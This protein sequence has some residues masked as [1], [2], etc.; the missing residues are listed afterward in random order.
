MSGAVR[1]ST[2]QA[3]RQLGISTRQLD[4]LVRRGLATPVV[5]AQGSGYYRE[6]PAA[7][8][9]RLAPIVRVFRVLRLPM[10]QE[11]FE[12]LAAQPELLA[13]IVE[14]FTPSRE[15]VSA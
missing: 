9:A 10:D 8:I 7:E 5:F 6:W 3:A 15:Q 11:M 4:Y 12:R 13:Q 2:P 1:T 14:L